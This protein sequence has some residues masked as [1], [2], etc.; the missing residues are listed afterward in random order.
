MRTI[1]VKVKTGCV[2]TDTEVLGCA[3]EKGAVQLKIDA[4]SIRQ[5]G[6]D[7]AQLFCR[8]PG[9][10][11]LPCEVVTLPEDGGVQMMLPDWALCERGRVQM[12][13]TLT[14]ENIVVRS[15]VWSMKVLP[16]LEIGGKPP[17]AVRAWLED[18][19]QSVSSALTFAKAVEQVTVSARS[20]PAGQAAEASGRIDETEGL[21]LTLG[22][23]AGAM[24]EKGERGETGAQGIQG[25]PGEKGDKGDKGD[26]GEPGLRGETGAGFAVMDYFADVVALQAAV[27]QP[28]PGD[29]YGVG[30]AQP[31][32]I[33]I[34]GSTSG[35]VNNGPLQGA[36]GDKG[37]DGERG[38]KGEK[39]DTGARGPR[40][41]KG[42]QGEK[43]DPGERGEP[44][45]AGS[46]AVVPDWVGDTKPVYTCA[47]VG[48]APPST[49]L[50]LA[51]PASG[52]SENVL[53]A[54]AA[55]ISV[56]S[57]LIIT[58]SPDCFDAWCEAG[59]RATEQREGS[60]VFGCSAQP[61]TD[62]T[63]NVL[64]VG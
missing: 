19:E 53:T 3:G 23:P 43:G 22:L 29:A 9:G 49:A 5:Q 63:A 6:A 10:Y 24:G 4:G 35:W 45:P 21:V 50:T 1:N 17:D 52:W 31:Y 58:P 40:G 34:Y 55:A 39:G 57:H 38:E 25:S 27:T 16:S 32:D 62:L 64:I 48:A 36:K 2:E 37:Q 51:L 56:G 26:R 54:A 14:G 13:L 44:G 61:S 47:E 41:E 33:Y 15:Y 20:L 60:L 11:T 18:V 30:T 8:M 12:Q 28:A 7:K 46:D 42:E 59:I